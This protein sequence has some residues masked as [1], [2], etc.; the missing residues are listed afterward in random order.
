MVLFDRDPFSLFRTAPS[1]FDGFFRAAESRARRAAAPLDAL[2]NRANL[3][4]TD[5]GAHLTMLV[6]G[7]GPD[8]VEVRVQRG[9]VTVIGN[10]DADADAQ[11]SFE[12][13]FRLPFPVEVDGV[14]A[15]IEHGV[16]EL[17]L[18]RSGADRPRIVPIAG[19]TPKT[20][21][22]PEGEDA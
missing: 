10:R 8:D 4:A 13:S 2:R 20:D 12:R 17:T 21:A 6:P 18:P 19:A 7:F 9:T 22:L 11:R 16:L 1:P 5:T 3:T 14:E 15:R